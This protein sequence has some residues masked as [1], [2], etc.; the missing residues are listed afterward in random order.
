MYDAIFG[1]FLQKQLQEGTSLAQSS[2]IV[3]IFPLTPQHF[4]VQ[5]RCRGLVRAGGAGVASAD[6]FEVGIF[7]PVDYLRIARP[8]E[9]VTW[10]GPP[11]VF[12]PNISDKAPL[13]CIGRL[14]PGTPLVD[15]IDQVFRI[16]TYQ[17]VTMREDDALNRDACAWAR[18]NQ[19]RFP[20]DS[21]PLKR[22]DLHLE[23]T[24]PGEGS[25]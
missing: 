15:I 23:I 3:R 7:F 22:R 25:R 17:K 14:F 8:F 9:V 24:E 18:R 4:A 2:D 20:I 1:A 12:H 13:I 11:N 5:L 6:C 10:F 16:V 21:R 19:D